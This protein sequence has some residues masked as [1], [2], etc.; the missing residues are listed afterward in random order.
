MIYTVYYLFFFDEAE[1]TV[2]LGLVVDLS[3]M[4][5]RADPHPLEPVLELG[6]HTLNRVVVRRVGWGEDILQPELVEPVDHIVAVVHPEVV[7]D[8]ADVVEE[9]PPPELLE[10][11]LELLLVHG[12]GKG[13]DQVHPSLPGY[14]CDDGDD[15]SGELTKVDRER[16][17]LGRPL[18]FGDGR[19][20]DQGLVEEDD[21]EAPVDQLMELLGHE[22]RLPLDA[23]PHHS[24][25]ELGDLDQLVADLVLLVDAGEGG[26][27]DLL[28]RELAQ[29]LC[30]P[31][32]QR[33]AG[34]ALQCRWACDVLDVGLA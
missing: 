1:D 28:L 16:L 12:L 13:H 20:G 19:L 27:A 21:A 30:E 23:E 9:V 2:N 22:G 17:L 7:H 14:A 31:L 24:V 10:V 15:L 8:D 32:P 34:L 25:R 33:H 6:E 5:Y 11:H 18:S 3:L 4:H 26:E 29:E